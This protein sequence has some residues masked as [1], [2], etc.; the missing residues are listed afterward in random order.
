MRKLATVLLLL[1]LCFGSAASQWNSPDATVI[2]QTV[3]E[4][5]VQITETGFDVSLKTDP[6]GATTDEITI[7]RTGGG[8]TAYTLA[9]SK[10]YDE[11]LQKLTKA[12]ALTAQGEAALLEGL[13]NGSQD[14]PAS[15]VATPKVWYSEDGVEYSMNFEIRWNLAGA[16]KISRLPDDVATAEVK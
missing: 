5:Q 12:D 6:I 13:A 3:V 7:W 16:V 15:N 4:Y 11:N 9:D 14:R 1:V 2:G 10:V 8:S